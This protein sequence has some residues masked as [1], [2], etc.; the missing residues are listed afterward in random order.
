MI[1]AELERL[2][3]DSFGHA[4]FLAR[5]FREATGLAWGGNGTTSGVI[6][7][8]LARGVLVRH[9]LARHD[10]RRATGGQYEYRLP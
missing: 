3:E 7:G 1:T 4:W 6:G 5:D 10:P 8:L 9:T 2:I